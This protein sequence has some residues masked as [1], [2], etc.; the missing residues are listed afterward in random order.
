M[1]DKMLQEKI[2]HIV[3][4]AILG[5]QKVKIK[6]RSLCNTYGIQF[7]YYNGYI[8]NMLAFWVISAFQQIHP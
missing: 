1:D 8:K 7:D 3:H 2:H 4:D 6:K 5:N